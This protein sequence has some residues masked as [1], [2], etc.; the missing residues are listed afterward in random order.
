MCGLVGVAGN[1]F[2]KDTDA[3]TQ[4]L[5]V[6]VLRG[7][8]STGVASAD[9]KGAVRLLKAAGPAYELMDRKGY[10]SVVTM[11][12]RVIIG[13]NRYGTMGARTS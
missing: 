12:Q 2:K 11:A 9:S 1:L 5:Y 3:F 7:D 4:M 6:D 10:D 8:H 13:H